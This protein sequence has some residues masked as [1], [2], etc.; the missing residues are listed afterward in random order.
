MQLHGEAYA[1]IR[2]HDILVPIRC[3]AVLLHTLGPQLTSEAAPEFCAM[4][5]LR[6]ARRRAGPAALLG[7][8]SRRIEASF[9]VR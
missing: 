8:C 6:V 1:A 5:S 4:T 3:D 9:Q 7:R 2:R